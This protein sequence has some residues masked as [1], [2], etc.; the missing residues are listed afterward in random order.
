MGDEQRVECE[1]GRSKATAED[2]ARFIDET[3][4]ADAFDWIVPLWA[5]ALCFSIRRPCLRRRRWASDL[6]IG[7]AREVFA[8]HVFLFHDIDIEM[9]GDGAN[10]RIPE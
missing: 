7:L 4:H 1:C 9:N 3:R 10:A 2:R 5:C 8:L 6:Y